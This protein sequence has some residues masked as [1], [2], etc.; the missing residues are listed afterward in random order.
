VTN[1]RDPLSNL[2]QLRMQ[3][4]DELQR[5][6]D[7]V[8]RIG[9]EWVMGLRHTTLR[10]DQTPIAPCVRCGN[11]ADD[12]TRD[13]FEFPLA[14]HDFASEEEKHPVCFS[15]REEEARQVAEAEILALL[16]KRLGLNEESR[17]ALETLLDIAVHNP[18]KVLRLE[19]LHDRVDGLERRLEDRTEGIR[20]AVESKL[21]NAN[22]RLF[23]SS[24]ISSTAL[25]LAGLLFGV[26]IALVL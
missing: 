13:A 22:T 21:E 17:S 18:D 15:C 9:D 10:A 23:I 1:E 12:P 5:I 8:G 6:R 20:D 25:F 2:P 16:D 19:R 26:V 4:I 3:V 11:I 7:S 24:L 14:D